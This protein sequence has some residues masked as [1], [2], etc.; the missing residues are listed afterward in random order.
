[1][2]T[3]LLA[4]LACYGVTEI[5]TASYAAKWFRSVFR[6][7]VWEVGPKC[8]AK[9]F[10]RW[11]KTETDDEEAILTDEA[12]T[13]YDGREIKGFDMV[14]CHFCVGFWVSVVAGA[15]F[16]LPPLHWLAIYGGSQFLWRVSPHDM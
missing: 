6:D 1:M 16:G 15:A 13:T 3:L 5:I 4:I 2:Q 14:A 11:F 12:D 10:V 8:I 7:V 9:H